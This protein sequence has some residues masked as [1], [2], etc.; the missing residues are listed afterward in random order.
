MGFLE[1]LWVGCMCDTVSFLN[2]LHASKVFVLAAPFL[3]LPPGLYFLKTDV[4]VM[5]FF[6]FLFFYSPG[7]LNMLFWSAI[8]VITS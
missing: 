5:S 4:E 8:W 2:G 7:N 3:F 6:I 1:S